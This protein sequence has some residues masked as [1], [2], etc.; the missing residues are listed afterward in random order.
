MCTQE[1]SVT[2]V[3]S[4]ILRYPEFRT[5]KDHTMGYPRFGWDIEGY[6]SFCEDIPG[7]PV[8]DGERPVQAPLRRRRL[9]SRLHPCLQLY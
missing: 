9:P 2:S 5:Y 7:Y 8:A 1:P 4:L 6:A 3:D